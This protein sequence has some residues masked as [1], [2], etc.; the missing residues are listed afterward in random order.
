[1]T[2]GGIDM[3][4]DAN[5]RPRHVFEIFINASPER[6]WD[7]ITK[8]EFTARYFY[9]A[10]FRSEVRAGTPFTYIAADGA[11]PIV[12]GEVLEAEPPRRLIYSWR[13]L[14]DPGLTADA[15]SRVTWELQP[16]HGGVTR[17]TV[18]HD[19][20]DGETPT[21]RRVGLRWGWVLSNL[22]TLLETGEPM[23][24]GDV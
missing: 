7:A 22:K 14:S 15:P 6:V 18:V 11:T 2:E 24:G 13:F 12:G 20:F 17:L 9:G 5:R 1:V 8:E 3:G 23:P 10:S 16:M 21:F 4:K 19:N